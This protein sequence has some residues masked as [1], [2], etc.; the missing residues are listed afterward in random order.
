MTAAAKCATIRCDI[1]LEASMEETNLD[2][3]SV[4][5]L[6]LR[7]SELVRDAEAGRISVITKHGRP[8][9]LTMPFGRRLLELGLDKEVALVLFA[10]RLLTMQK[11]AKLAG[12]T[13]DGFIDLL[14]Q[15]STVAVDYPPEELD[16]E[17][18]IPI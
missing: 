1:Y 13:L 6:R 17:L 8:A 5:D 9:A 2:V 12:M 4:R 7:S 16:D 18:S 11:A 10:N 14:Q 3:Y 15:T